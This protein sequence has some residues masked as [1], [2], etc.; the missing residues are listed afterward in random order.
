MSDTLNVSGMD[1]AGRAALK[2]LILTL[3]DSKAITC[4]L[5]A[6]TQPPQLNPTIAK[7][8]APNPAPKVAG[9]NHVGNCIISLSCLA[10]HQQHREFLFE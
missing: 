8:T 9:F 10:L 7:A 4:A 6:V 5:G 2:R 3:A 1:E